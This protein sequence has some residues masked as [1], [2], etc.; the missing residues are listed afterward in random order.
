VQLT[1]VHEYIYPVVEEQHKV[2]VG[3]RESSSSFKKCSP[4]LAQQQPPLP[5]KAKP[6]KA[7]KDPNSM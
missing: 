6:K 1:A 2:S 7:A 4:E 5:L 3:R